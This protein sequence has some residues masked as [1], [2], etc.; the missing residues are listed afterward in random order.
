MRRKVKGGIY[1]ALI[2]AVALTGVLY[3]T[4]T[5]ETE[6]GIGQHEVTWHTEEEL[7]QLCEVESRI[8]RAKQGNAEIIPVS[9][10]ATGYETVC[11]GMQA[12]KKEDAKTEPVEKEGTKTAYLTFDDGPSRQTEKVLDILEQYRIKAS[13][14]VVSSNMTETGI[15][16]LRRTAAEGHV[17]GMHSDTHDYNKIYA[18]VESLLEDYE[19][20]YNMIKDIT[21]ITPQFYRFPGG[22]YNSVGRKCIKQTIPEMERRGF[23]YFDWNVTA[24]D[25]VGNPT[26]ASIM[27]NVFRDI[28]RTDA[29]VILMHDGPC[30]GL[31]VEILPEIIEEL[32]RRGYSFDTVDNREPC[33]FNW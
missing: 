15:D 19:K 5:Q 20:V 23:L 21:G 22:S 2:A 31:T 24:E 12:E 10:N 17:I 25:A 26:A 3:H 8:A 29:P 9:T 27:K 32:L 16:V 18:S 30:N 14:F 11:P 13:F 4:V 33:V 1:A 28:D 7:R 6:G